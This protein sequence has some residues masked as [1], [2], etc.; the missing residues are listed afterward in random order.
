MPGVPL[1]EGVENTPVNRM[2]AASKAVFDAGFD[3]LE[4]SV[5]S[6]VGLSDEDY[7]ELRERG[8]RVEACNCFI[9]GTLPICGFGAELEAYVEKALARVAGVG[10]KI[11]VFGSGGARS[12]PE[13]TSTEEGMEE[14]KRFL[15]MCEIYAAKN[16]VTVVIEPLNSRECNV[17]NYVSEGDALAK[18]VGLPHIANLA[19][20]YHVYQ[21][22][23]PT[24]NL[25]K[26]GAL[27]KHAHIAEGDTRKY[28][29]TGDGVFLTAFAR[30]LKEG[31]YDG[32]VSAE[33][34]F[35]DF[36]SEGKPAAD[37]MRALF[38]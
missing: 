2:M 26:C 18:E 28:P 38:A 21:G 15:R 36:R 25:V 23:E 7:A 34:G 30:A 33:C 3:Y 10:G 31:G 12:I 37:Y 9:P 16:D 32:R 22:N 35:S 8:F 6:L 20:S 4:C 11:V 19:D 17:L 13:G 5:G 29:G 24:E 27:I 14:I 1:P